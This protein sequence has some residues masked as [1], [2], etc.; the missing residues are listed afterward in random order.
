MSATSSSPSVP[1]Q[2]PSSAATEFQA[3]QF[4]LL[5]RLLKV[6]T[7]IV[8]AVQAVHGGGLAPVGTVDVVPLVDQVDGAGNAIPHLTIYGRPYVR[9]QG[10][11]NAVILDPQVGDLGLMVFCS[12]DISSV[13]T[14]KQHGPPASS[15]IFDYAD[16]LYVGGTLNGLP[17]NYVMFAPGGAIS[18]V[19]T[20]S[21]SIEA[22]Q[23]NLTG[24]VNANGAQIS[25]AG[26]VTDALG[27]VLG[28][29]AHSGVQ[30]GGSD[31]GPPVP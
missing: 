19:S 15:R 30:S 18:M 16:G 13:I 14:S 8:V 11:V 4:L 20:Q 17:Q 5:Q 1:F 7:A 23:I 10:G 24:A 3:L 26:E 22:P 9:V 31:T 21:V 28:T 2:Q 29:H 6:Q 12:R 25:T 27:I